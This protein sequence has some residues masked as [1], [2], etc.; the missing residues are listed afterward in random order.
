VLS[1]TH[2]YA[3]IEPY[4]SDYLS[5]AALDRALE[6]AETAVRRGVAPR[7]RRSM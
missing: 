4:D 7:R 1:E 3:Y 5:P 6:L 2:V